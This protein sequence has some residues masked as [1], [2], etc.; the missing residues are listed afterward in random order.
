MYYEI[1]SI[2]EGN[3]LLTLVKFW[4]NMC[5]FNIVRLR[6]RP[7][8][9]TRITGRVFLRG[10]CSKVWLSGRVNYWLGI[11]FTP[12]PRPHKVKVCLHENIASPLCLLLTLPFGFPLS[13]ANTLTALP[14]ANIW[15]LNK[16]ESWKHTK[17]EWLLNKQECCSSGPSFGG[18]VIS[19][20]I[21]LII[22]Y[23]ES[24]GK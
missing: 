8:G 2:T 5:G 21:E 23:S 24:Q 14:M 19:V 15:F 10:V 3:M 7:G 6:K 20:F 1:H 16:S 17:V 9:N 12:C 13:Q 22:Q 4:K 18:V 11:I